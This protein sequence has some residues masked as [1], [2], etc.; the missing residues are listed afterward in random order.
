[1]KRS[2]YA[3]IALVALY[4]ACWWQRANVVPFMT[5]NFPQATRV[6]AT[7]PGFADVI[8]ENHIITPAQASTTDKPVNAPPAVP[9]TSTVVQQD[10]FPVF[11]SGLGTVQP[12]NTVTVRSRVDG[13]ITKILFKQGDMVHEG[14]PLVEIDKRPFQ[15]ALDQ[16]MSKKAQ[17][18]ASLKD[19]KLNLERYNSLAKQDFAS[20]QQLDTQQALVEQ[21][22]AQIQG[23][24][25]SIDN[26]RTQLSYTTINAPLTGKTGFR[27]IDQG[28]IVHASDTNG[29]VTIVSLQPISVVFSAPEDRLQEINAALAHGI[30]PVNALSSDGLTVLSRGKL[31]LV[32]NAVNAASGTIGLK[33]VFQ[34]LDNNLWPGLSISTQMRTDVKKSVLIVPETVIQHGPSGLF[35]FVIGDDNKVMVQSVKVAQIGSGFALVS[36]F[37]GSGHGIENRAEGGLHPG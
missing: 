35:A 20:H 13:Q 16:A 6:F 34:N 30:V 4:G 9:V 1:M 10:D 37:A 3:L 7:L 2:L 14:D 33:A 8:A 12:F 15:A 22:T 29:I 17:D 36:R 21:L 5:R 23:D 32:D 25:A 31:L 24:Q 11:L 19:A 26:A 28:N 27:L 18:E